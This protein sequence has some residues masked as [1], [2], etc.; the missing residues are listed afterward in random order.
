VW[1]A[2]GGALLRTLPL[3][4]AMYLFHLSISPDGTRIAAAASSTRRE[5][6]VSVWEA[7]TGR[8]VFDNIREQK[9]DP[10]CVTFDPTGKYLVREGPEHTVQVRDANTGNVLGVVGRHDLQIW[11]MAFSPD[12]SRLATASI[13]GTVRVWAWDPTR[14]GPEQKPQLTLNVRI[15]GYC[16]RVAFSPD[17]A[18]LAT[19]GEGSLVNIWDAKTGAVLRTLSGH[20]GDVFAV[21]FS[22]DG[23]WLATA[24]EDTTV[25]I[26]DTA[27]WKLLH[28]LRGHTGLVMSLAFSPDSQRLASGSRDHTMKVWDTAGWDNDL[29]H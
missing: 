25:R 2:K 13:D 17:G 22:R 26:W 29:D 4:N 18:H 20:T 7:A 1:D 6:V 24:G 9:S 16:N 27:S 23:R 5:A 19:G 28:T 12:G 14:L 15:D 8:E 11:C 21:A 10:F 3:P